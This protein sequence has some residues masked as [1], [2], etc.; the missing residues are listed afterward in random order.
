MEEEK[1]NLDPQTVFTLNHSDIPKGTT[2]CENHTW[3]TLNE[4]ERI[5]HRCNTIQIIKHYA[6]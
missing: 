5:C 1:S 4:H 6:K 3:E 2:Q